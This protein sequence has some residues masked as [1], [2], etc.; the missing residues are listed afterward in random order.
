MSRV[1]VHLTGSPFVGGP[2][3]QMLGLAEHLSADYQTRFLLFKDRGRSVAMRDETLRR[4]F[5]CLTLEHDAPAY[6]RTIDEI[7]GALRALA[8]DVVVCHGYKA[9]IL[10]GWAARR[11]GCRAIAV[12]HGWTA[13]TWK[14]RLNET[15]DRW[16]LRRFDRVV[17]VS[18]AQAEKVR[19]AGVAG[20]KIVVIRNAVD[21]KP[22]PVDAAA[23]AEICRGFREPKRR[24]IGAAGRFSPE[25]GYEQFVA[26]AALVR[27]THPDVGFILFGDGPLRASL[28]Q[29]IARRDL[30]G[31]VLLGG[32]R[33]D[34]P[35]L[36][37]G[38]ELAVLPSYTEGLPVMALEALA[39]GAPVVA[40]AVGGTPEAI[41]DGVDGFLVPPRDPGAI[42]DRLGVLLDDAERRRDMGRAGRERVVAEFTFDAQ[43]GAFE[44]LFEEL[45]WTES[46][47]E[48]KA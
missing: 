10:G 37:P 15:L 23:L 26:A 47:V 20:A 38:F 8:A 6:R 32:F 30:V 9:D 35:R 45:L 44:R 48:A 27:K 28:E 17:C 42:A 22:E 2:E 39:A 31:H 18:A 11:I 16:A 43:A 3:R 33:T 34:L 13:A 46:T 12:S 41:R 7:G 29:E 21:L 1:I 25:K 14:V 40:T 4:G 36:W 24:L 19:R 5:D